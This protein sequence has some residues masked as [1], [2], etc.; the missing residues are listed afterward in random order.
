MG[1]ASISESLQRLGARARL[2]LILQHAAGATAIMAGAVILIGLADYLLRLPGWVRGSLLVAGLAVLGWWL[3]TVLRPVLA[4]RPAL[5]DLALRAEQ[6]YPELRG[7]LASAVDFSREAIIGTGSDVSRRMAGV[8]IRDTAQ[9]WGGRDATRLVHTGRLQKNAFWFVASAGAFFGVLL[10]APAYWS[11][12]VQRVLIPWSSAHWPKRFGVVD[13]TAVSV[14]A[15]GASLPIR[16]V[17]LRSPLPPE[18][19]D[20]SV[21]Y[22]FIAAGKS[23]PVRRELLT[24]QHR[25][26]VAEPEKSPG[27]EPPPSGPMFERLID[28]AGEAVE[29]R[30]ATTDDETSWT[31]VK[32]VPPPS[33]VNTLATVTPPKYAGGKPLEL[34][35]GTGVDE[36][37]VAPPI[38]EGSRIDLRIALSKPA[39]LPESVLGEFVDPDDQSTAKAADKPVVEHEGALWK[40]SWT[41]RKSLRLE[42]RPVDESGISAPDAAVYRFD[43]LADRPAEA[44]ITEPQSDRGVL[45]SATVKVVAEA[46]DD[47]GLASMALRRQSFHPAGRPGGEKSPPG[48]AMEPQ[49]EPAVIAEL[50]VAGEKTST[51]RQEL[52]LTPLDLK[53]GDEV[54]LT[55]M[56]K[57]VFIAPE[58]GGRAP[59]ISTPRILRI[60]SEA[61]FVEEVRRELASVRESAIRIDAQQQEV[62][63]RTADKG[64]DTGA[65]RGQAQISERLSRQNEAV[66][67]VGERVEENGLSDAA[68]KQVLREANESL[69]R[70]GKSSADAGKTLDQAAASQPSQPEAEKPDEP[71]NPAASEAAKAA[72]KDQQAVRDEMQKLA[73][74]LDRGQDT[75]VA[76]NKIEQ[77]AKAQRELASQSRAKA[78]ATAGKNAA[79]LSQQEKTDLER[80]VE[81]QSQ[82]AEELRKLTQDMRQK[83]SE[84]EKH[85]AA[86]AAGMREAANRSE[87][88]QVERTMRSASQDVKQN[89]MN[90]AAQQQDQAAKSLQQMLDDMQK[91]EQNR[92]LVLKRL[93]KQLAE[94]IE[95][96]VQQN[97]AE[98]ASL[99]KAQQAQGGYAGLDRGMISLNQNTLGVMDQAAGD[100]GGDKGGGG[101]L[102]PIAKLLGKASDSQGSAIKQLRAATV[103]PVPVRADENQSLEYLK[104]A[105]DRAKEQEK[106]LDDQAQ[107]QKRAELKKL[108]KEMLEKQAAL[109]DQ[110]KAY[111]AQQ[112]LS[113]KDRVAMRKLA[114]EQKAV[115]DRLASMVSDTKELAEADVFSFAHRRLDALT[116]NATDALDHA[117]ASTAAVS[118]Q[119]AAVQIAAIIESLTDP[120]NDSKFSEGDQGGGGA[121]AGKGKKQPLIVPVAQIRLLRA[122]QIEVATA[123]TDAEN[124]AGDPATKAK[125]AK[126]LAQQQREIAD[127]AKALMSK[128]SGGGG[129][130]PEIP[131]FKPVDPKDDPKDQPKDQ[132]AP[133]DPPPAEPKAPPVPPSPSAAAAKPNPLPEVR[134]AA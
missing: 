77:M 128:L 129:E 50:N 29:Y 96:L 115:H 5:V 20:I 48:G 101:E 103:D 57:D 86:A 6:E 39:E 74:L 64:A 97:T 51:L 80:I 12:G 106:K 100:K 70:A 105:L 37:A 59:S 84:L 95:R 47:V 54:R 11:I 123:T 66:K 69:N 22:R 31:K 7:K 79:E 125:I 2:V 134:R 88:Q 108:Y 126:D 24:W 23:G 124:A 16:G 72:E 43:A 78:A 55:A 127:V 73:E 40:I 117:E 85:D 93:L 18:K 26:M 34:E 63:A 65:R 107:A 102:Q 132:P 15:L 120:K 82:L 21:E 109:R 94:A 114:E 14:H 62:Q 41:L 3:W 118:Q 28:P 25:D 60:I 111:A 44:S 8:V 4:L 27:G 13:A 113:R 71:K 110:S 42:V 112:E 89:R 122:M 32:L 83:A 17:L 91:A 116:T 104:L 52:D 98:I 9:A 131:G 61:Q 75:W 10:A 68:L 36:R 92:Q 67:R 46:R 119:G 35:L 58:G 130:A 33:I 76:R 45:A 133:L 1:G 30:L 99:E 87:Q 38:L 81:K 49:G 121:G 56:A 19:T 53:P 90:D